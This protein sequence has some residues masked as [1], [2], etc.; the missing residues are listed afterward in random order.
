MH[1]HDRIV[2][3]DAQICF[4]RFIYIEANLLGV[5]LHGRASKRASRALLRNTER[6][7]LW[8]ISAR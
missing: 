1:F 7:D 5:T 2:L 4:L 8:Q 6:P 3:H